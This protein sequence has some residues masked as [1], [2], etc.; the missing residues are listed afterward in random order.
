MMES[1]PKG[2]S[3]RDVLKG[4]AVASAGLAAGFFAG[5]EAERGTEQEITLKPVRSLT[6]EEGNG[7]YRFS[8]FEPRIDLGLPGEGKKAGQILD[9]DGKP[10]I[11]PGILGLEIVD[12][13]SSVIR[14][15]FLQ[16]SEDGKALV[17]DAKP[18]SPV[19][20]VVYSGPLGLYT[21]APISGLPNELFLRE[22]PVE[23]TDTR[24]ASIKT[25][26]ENAEYKGVFIPGGNNFALFITRPND[27]LNKLR[28]IDTN[29]Y[30]EE[31]INLRMAKEES[32]QINTS[33]IVALEGDRLTFAAEVDNVPSICTV[34]L[35]GNNKGLV[36]PWTL[37]E[38]LPPE[39]IDTHPLIKKEVGNYS[40][41]LRKVSDATG[42]NPI[43]EVRAIHLEAAR[44]PIGES[45]IPSVL[46]IAIPIRGEKL[47]VVSIEENL[48]IK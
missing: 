48:P 3:R 22:F 7:V 17:F 33:R 24:H 10:I 8:G 21:L 4:G 45:E 30:R 26:K 6:P 44:M 14:I 35:K 11:N 41:S 43:L 40:L 9:E 15:P 27:L 12:S 37:G 47:P 36:E 42:G 31:N 5:R 39:I 20:N 16:M 23:E 28:V 1:K 34:C 18:S 19:K 2:V 32:L 38:N 25:V 46:N 29:S 13:N